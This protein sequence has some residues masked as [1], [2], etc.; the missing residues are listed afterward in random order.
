[1]SVLNVHGCNGWCTS[2]GMERISVWSRHRVRCHS[3]ATPTP[4]PRALCSTITCGVTNAEL[5]VPGPLSQSISGR[6]SVRSS[7]EM[8]R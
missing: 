3:H 8:T 6:S 7:Q 4:L 2:V 5:L 1:M